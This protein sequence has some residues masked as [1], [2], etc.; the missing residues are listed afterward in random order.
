M[1]NPDVSYLRWTYFDEEAAVLV[2]HF[3]DF[4][5]WETIDPQLVFVNHKTTRANPEH[6]VNT[7]QI[8]R[9]IEQNDKLI[10]SK[11]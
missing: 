10:F 9:E 5:P 4:G 6:D 8:L 3:E 1:K 7:I 11:N 2:G